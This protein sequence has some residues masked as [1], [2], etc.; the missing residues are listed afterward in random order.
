M[1]CVCVVCIWVNICIQVFQQVVIL[2]TVK[3]AFCCQPPHSMTTSITLEGLLIRHRCPRCLLPAVGRPLGLKR[4]RR[5]W[6]S[7][8]R[9][10]STKSLVNVCVKISTFQVIWLDGVDW[11][12]VWLRIRSG[13]SVSFHKVIFPRLEM[14]PFASII[15]EGVIG[16]ELTF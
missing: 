4:R 3:E 13:G 8:A 5:Q 6:L 11:F 9:I 2:S 10:Y 14:L 15:G 12:E 1:R 7:D 16:R